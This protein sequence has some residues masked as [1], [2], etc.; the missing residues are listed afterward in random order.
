MIKE[1]IGTGSTIEE[2]KEQAVSLLGAGIDDDIEIEVLATP[3]KKTLG[4]F[5]GSPARV[6]VY[7]EVPDPVSPRARHTTPAKT[8]ENPKKPVQNKET[9]KPAV[10]AKSAARPS[11]GNKPAENRTPQKP[12]AQKQAAQTPAQQ[13]KPAAP[14][15]PA[16]PASEVDANTPAGRAVAYLGKILQSMGL[17]A[18]TM[19]VSNVEGGSQIRL[20]GDGLG[21]IIGRRGETLDALQYLASLAANSGDGNYY[22]VVLNTGNYRE[23][24][25]QT[26]QGLARRMASQVLRTGR[27]RS[28]EPM[29]PYERRIIHT[30]VQ[31][32]NGVTSNSTGDGATRRVVISSV[33]AGGAFQ[34]A[35]RARPGFKPRTDRAPQRDSRPP[36]RESQVIPA[37]ESRGHIANDNT[38]KPQV[39]DF[40]SDAATGSI[41]PNPKK[42]IAEKTNKTDNAAPLYGRIDK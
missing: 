8:A 34:P 6:R 15:A 23:K 3:K 7:I 42:E 18:V 28:L 5:G 12:A 41:K 29:N 36:R 35:D 32:I 27:S 20:T 1:A 14:A 2:A 30:E 11:A 19:E 38:S 25:E 16:I 9:G 31:N 40:L 33:R 26:L 37:D 17:G 13:S 4:L 10:P 24:R 21:A 22:R 39:K